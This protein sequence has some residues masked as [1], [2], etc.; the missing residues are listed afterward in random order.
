MVL[1]IR[2]RRHRADVPPMPTLSHRE[3]PRAM[4]L[5]CVAQV[6]EFTRR[7]LPTTNA[8]K[9]RVVMFDCT[10]MR[11]GARTAPI[12]ANPRRQAAIGL[13]AC[14]PRFGASTFFAGL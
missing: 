6:D 8:E 10:R 9:A 7:F 2:L 12:P 5:M 1:T 4:P 14:A 11:K 13:R 3:C